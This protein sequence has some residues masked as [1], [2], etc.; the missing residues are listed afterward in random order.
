MNKVISASFYVSQTINQAPASKGVGSVSADQGNESFSSILDRRLV[1]SESL[2]FS[3][4]AEQ[5][6]AARHV[7]LETQELTKVSQAVDRAAEKGARNTLVVGEE[8]AL[9]VNVP[10]R[11]VVTAMARG[12]MND[13]VVTN[14]DSTVFVE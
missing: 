6:M 12:G 7:K 3:A 2:R 1:Q 13:S 9:I 4:H 11:V 8:Y 14:I 5:R 10:G